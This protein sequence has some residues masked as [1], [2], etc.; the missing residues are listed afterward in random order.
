MG[1]ALVLSGLLGALAGWRGAWIGYA[2]LA[3][4]AAAGLALLRERFLN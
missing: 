1:S 2:A 3:F 4:A